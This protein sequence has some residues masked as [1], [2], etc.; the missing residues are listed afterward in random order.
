MVVLADCVRD[1]NTALKAL[2]TYNDTAPD[3]SKPATRFGIASTSEIYGHE[4]DRCDALAGEPVHSSLEFRRAIDGAKAG[5]ALIPKAV[6]TRDTE[7]LHKI[8][9]ELRSFNNLLALTFG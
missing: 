8:L 7:L 9:I 4:L 6:A 5:L 3:W 1:A 2:M